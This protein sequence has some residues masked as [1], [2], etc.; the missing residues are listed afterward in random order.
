[1]MPTRRFEAIFVG[2]C[3]RSGTTLL[4]SLLNA[5]PRILMTYE[6]GLPI[7]LH[8]R[9]GRLG[10]GQVDELLDAILS[11]SEFQGVSRK[12]I[13]AALGNDTPSFPAVIRA[14]FSTLAQSEGKL[15]WGDKS[16][17]YA[18]HFLF[19]KQMFPDCALIHICR[20]PRAVAHSLIDKPWG[21]NTA[22]H[23]AEYWRNVVT[24][25]L[26]ARHVIGDEQFLNVSYEALVTDP[27]DQV[28]QICE[29]LNVD[30]DNAMFDAQLR[31]HSVPHSARGVHPHIGH[32]INP[33]QTE[34]WRSMPHRDIK[35]IEAVCGRLMDELAYEQIAGTDGRGVAFG[36]RVAYAMQARFRRLRTRLVRAN[37]RNA[38]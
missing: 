17:R 13:R 11:R 23:A 29:F 1:M 7:R 12:S 10:A 34:K 32:P 26:H 28:A 20:D 35:T 4:Q 15:L 37:G 25:A 5:H 27:K 2:G 19:L 36:R 9:F 18:N 30:M 22:L 8:G 33:D 3:D 24:A 16:P 14:A 31:A 21:A 6:L 38:S